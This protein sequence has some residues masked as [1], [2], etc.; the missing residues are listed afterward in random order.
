M[1]ENT[2]IES[3]MPEHVKLRHAEDF[4]LSFFKVD[5]GE[6]IVV[7]FD[8]EDVSWRLFLFNIWSIKDIF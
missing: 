7:D 1:N 2:E 6:K 4:D 8:N 3:I 5:C